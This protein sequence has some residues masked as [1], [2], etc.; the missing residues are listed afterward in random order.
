MP[1]VKKAQAQGYEVIITNTNDNY[2]DGNRIVGSGSPEEHAKAVW[3]TIVRPSNTKSIA[4][5][6]HSY[7]GVVVCSLEKKFKD[8]FEK[9]VFAAAFT[10][11]VHGKEGSRLANI[12]INFV[13]STK[14]LG[15]V[16]RGFSNDGM[17]RV[18][19]GHPK[20]EMTSFSCIEALFEFVEKKFVE[21]RGGTENPES[22]ENKKAKVDEL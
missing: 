13:S 7:G 1:Y 14:P 20:H 3:E 6:A 19:A 5:V 8:D 18:S 11:S 15:A 22:P 10:D 12:G 21:E 17:L 16:E 4:I 9:K 2:R